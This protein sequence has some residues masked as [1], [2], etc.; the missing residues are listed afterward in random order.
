MAKHIICD[1]KEDSTISTETSPQIK[2]IDNHKKNEFVNNTYSVFE[3]RELS[4]Y[5]IE[6]I[7]ITAQMTAKNGT[8]FLTKIFQCDQKNHLVEF[9]K[10][11]HRGFSYFTNLVDAYKRVLSPSK[12]K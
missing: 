9:T 4:C 8:A 1:S 12:E 3:P 6:V 2:P 10:S 7:K 11:H 5:E